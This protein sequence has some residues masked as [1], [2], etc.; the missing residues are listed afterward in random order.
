MMLEEASTSD[1]FRHPKKE[2]RKT[3]PEIA[4]RREFGWAPQRRNYQLLDSTL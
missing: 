3:N 1:T 2:G 4:G